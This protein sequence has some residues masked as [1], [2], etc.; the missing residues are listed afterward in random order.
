MSKQ[1]V[2]IV[3]YGMGNVGSIANMCKKIGVRATVSFD[4]DVILSADSLILPGVGAFPE[5]MRRLHE[6]DLVPLLTHKVCEE[7]VP[8]LGICLGMQLMTTHSEEGNIAGLG[9]IN[10]RTVRFRSA[11]SDM[12]VPHMGWNLAKP[13]G[14]HP[15]WRNLAADS[16]YYFVHSFHVEVDDPSQR[17]AVTRYYYDFSSAV[18]RENVAGVQFHPE[19]SHRFGMALLRNFLQSNN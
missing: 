16:R 4:R 1:K 8:T 9:W 5:G 17:L 2:V 12:R 18:Q 3:D 13:V 6:L 15:L 11:D 14:D 19:K 10:G 7:K